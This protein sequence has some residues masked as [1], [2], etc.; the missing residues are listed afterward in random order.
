[1]K[2]NKT[3]RDNKGKFAKKSL[4][5]VIFSWLA[6]LVSLGILYAAGAAVYSIFSSF[7]SCDANSAGLS[8]VSCGKQ[9]LNF[10]DLVIVGLFIA[11]AAL[12]ITLFTAAW[13]ASLRRGTI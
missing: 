2:L 6:S 9:S 13:Q 10:G 3:R 12:V 1:M 7:R 5:F 4:K 11:S 8:I